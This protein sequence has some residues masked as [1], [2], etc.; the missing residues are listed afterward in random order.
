[1]QNRYI[2]SNLILIIIPPYL[3]L[4]FDLFD[5]LAEFGD[6]LVK[7]GT[8]FVDVGVSLRQ[9]FIYSVPHSSNTGVQRL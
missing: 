3:G 8:E 2:I 9:R 6:V 7:V 1:M 5:L 4:L